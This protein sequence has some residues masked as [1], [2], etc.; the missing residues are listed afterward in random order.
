MTPASGSGVLSG[1]P[2]DGTYTILQYHL[3]WPSEHVFNGVSYP[4]ELHIV[5]AKDGVEDPVHTP[6]GL[7]VLGFVF[8]KGSSSSAALKPLVDALPS[9]VESGAKVDLSSSEFK[10]EDVVNPVM[11][12]PLYGYYQGSL[13]TPPCTEVVEW[14]NFLTPL[15]VGEEDIAKF[16][17][18][19]DDD[20]KVIKSNTRLGIYGDFDE[21]DGVYYDA[22]L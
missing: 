20:G 22:S 18:L 13:T 16:E 14:I 11:S 5:T 9:I 12:T 21:R 7:S 19:K 3:H 6:M 17:A 8:K 10:L 2:L 1:G 4:L 15:E